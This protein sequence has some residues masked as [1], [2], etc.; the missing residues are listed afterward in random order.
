MLE[1]LWARVS[2]Q[3][4]TATLATTAGDL[5]ERWALRGF[6]AVHLAAALEVATDD[7]VMATWDLGCPEQRKRPGLRVLPAELPGA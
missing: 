6:D 2:V 4:V 1:W 7:L 5:A 3:E